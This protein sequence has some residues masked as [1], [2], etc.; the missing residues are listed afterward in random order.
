[1]SAIYSKSTGSVCSTL[2]Y[3][4]MHTV[5]VQTKNMCISPSDFSSI[6]KASTHTCKHI[7]HIGL[8]F[9]VGAVAAAI[10][11]VAFVVVVVAAVFAVDELSSMLCFIPKSRK[12]KEIKE[13]PYKQN[14]DEKMIVCWL[15]VFLFRL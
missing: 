4:Y 12:K 7:L 11:A 6:Y 8:L 5:H 15:T 14:E 2:L 9:C 1:M 10:A 13:R 3:A